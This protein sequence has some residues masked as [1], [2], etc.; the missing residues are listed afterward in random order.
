MALP[1]ASVHE[2]RD[3][4]S[5]CWCDHWDMNALVAAAPQWWF[6]HVITGWK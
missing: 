1:V 3:G 6:E 4:T 5:T 2:L